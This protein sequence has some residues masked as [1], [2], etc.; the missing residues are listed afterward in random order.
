MKQQNPKIKVG[1][2]S[3]DMN[4]VGTEI[5]LTSLADKKI[6][7]NLIT[8]IYAP[9]DNL[10]YTSNHLGLKLEFNLINS[11]ENSKINK[12]N[13]IDSFRKFAN[14]NFGN[15]DKEM[16]Q[17]AFESIR[18][19]VKD[20]NDKKIDVL[21]TPPINKRAI[22]SDVFPFMGHTDYI[23]SKVKGKATM[24]MVSDELKVA[25]LT[26]HIPIEKVAATI[27]KEL[28][29][30]KIKGIHE[31]L[32]RDF[33]IKN[34]KIAILSIDPHAG[35]EGVISKNDQRIM[36]PAIKVLTEK[37]LLVYG[38]CPSDSFFGSREYKKYDITVASFHDQGLIPFKTL[39][40]GQGVNYTSGL[41]RIRTS[42]DHGTAFSIAGKGQASNKSL[43]ASIFLA[44]K[45]FQKRNFFELIKK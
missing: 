16:G 20:L 43:I 23:N 2:S 34:P 25:L 38:P 7:G 5:L 35:D 26:E 40:F 29:H 9:L 31:T 13:V 18:R 4:G 33:Q 1:F 27:T 15:I 45:I 42:P 3:G 14:V 12:I 32:V 41:E 24:M 6:P 44:I 36:T 19:S 39:S 22:H 21:V 8:I 10:K 17:T 28:I 37:G 30:D 11:P